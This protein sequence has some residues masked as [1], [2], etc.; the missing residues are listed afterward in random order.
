M[1]LCQIKVQSDLDRNQLT[2]RSHS[3]MGSKQY[4]STMNSTIQISDKY[5]V[6]YNRIPN[7]FNAVLRTR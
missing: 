4:I 1:N 7:K 3:E 2:K 5:N 6:K